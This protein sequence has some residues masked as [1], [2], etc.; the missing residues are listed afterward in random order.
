LGFNS[1]QVPAFHPSNTEEAAGTRMQ[2]SPV[3]NCLAS[4]LEYHLL[5]A[6][7]L[8]FISNPDYERLKINTS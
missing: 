8:G 3:S 5:L 1:N 6:H 4:E 7:D 2:I